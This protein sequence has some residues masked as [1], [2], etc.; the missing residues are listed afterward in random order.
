M[1]RHFGTL[2][3]KEI[4]RG[5][6]IKRNEHYLEVLSARYVQRGEGQGMHL[7]FMDV[8]THKRGKL[9]L[10]STETAE[11]AELDS[12][13]VEVESFDKAR[14][15]LVLSDARHNR[16]DIPVAF[17]TWAKEGVK[18]GTLLN[19]ILDGEKFVKLTLPADV[20]VTR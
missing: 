14:G 7:E 13:P 17:A 3:S 2:V 18:T 15:M 5:A 11:K 20:K 6:V 19:L 4:S 9:H 8:Q 1:F 16:I 12:Y 10:K